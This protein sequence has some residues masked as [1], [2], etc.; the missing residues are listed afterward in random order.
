MATVV[1]DGGRLLC[2]EERA[3][4]RLVINQPAGHLE[5]DEDL[6]AA[7]VRETLEESAWTVEPTAFIGAYQWTSP[8]HE[9]GTPGRHY[10]RFALAAR[11]LAHDP[12]RP[13]D[14]GVVRALWLTPQELRARSAEHRSP[15]VWRVVEDL[16]AGARHPLSML[17]RVR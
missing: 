8:P 12:S 10:V 17:R 6:V 16:L 2:I 4:G 7:A 11:P 3:G 9:D 15:L 1:G 14:D 13:L 5:P